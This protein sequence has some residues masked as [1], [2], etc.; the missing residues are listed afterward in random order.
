MIF[1][2]ILSISAGKIIY[3]NI[4]PKQEKGNRMREEL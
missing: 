1:A 3:M 4:L 2:E